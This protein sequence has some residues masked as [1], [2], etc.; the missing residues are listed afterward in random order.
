MRS[1]LFVPADQPTKIE[2]AFASEADVVIVDLEDSIAL[3]QKP[4]ARGI[5]IEAAKTLQKRA[6]YVRINALDMNMLAEDLA[7]VAAV[8]PDGII[9]PKCNGV[10][11]VQ[12]LETHLNVLEAKH[13]LPEIKILP[14]V[15]ETAFGVLNMASYAT[16]AVKSSR[17]IG[18]TWGAEDLSAAVGASHNRY[19]HG[20]YT[21]VPRLA[22]AMTILGASAASVLAI[23]A[24]YPNFKD[25]DGLKAETEAGLRDG[26]CGKMAIH[27]AQVPVINAVYTPSAEAI[28]EAQAIIT[29]FEAAPEAGVINYN[30]RMLDKPHLV[31]AHKVLG[32]MH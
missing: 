6:F 1:F 14:I 31:Q 9:L 30:G 20:V 7:L 19:A 3:A 12:A 15:T 21:D 8:K 4:A 22:R 18:M 11:D 23:D 2:K 29:A 26:F 17:L 24:V 28:A 25:L 5:F 32:R 13:G 27:P 10:Q 16:A